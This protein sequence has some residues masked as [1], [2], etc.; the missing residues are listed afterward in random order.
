[1]KLPPYEIPDDIIKIENSKPSKKRVSKVE[2]CKNEMSGCRINE[3]K[4]ID[5]YKTMIYFE[6]ASEG[7]FLRQFDQTNIQLRYSGG[8]NGRYY[9]SVDVS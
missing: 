3:S 9:I 5:A 1:M 4:Y 7:R 6:E 2:N 8:K